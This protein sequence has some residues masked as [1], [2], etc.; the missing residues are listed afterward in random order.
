M[1]P[2]KVRDGGDEGW[3]WRPIFCPLQGLRNRT[4]LS[5]SHA[6][7]Y[8][9]D[10]FKND[11]LCEARFYMQDGEATDGFQPQPSTA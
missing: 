3:Y 9:R 10:D 8:P 4:V 5:L 6:P 2:E 7:F 1:C 11:K